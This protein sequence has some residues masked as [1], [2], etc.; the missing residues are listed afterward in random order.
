MSEITSAD[1]CQRLAFRDY[2][3]SHPSTANEYRVLK[4]RLAHEFPKDVAGYSKGKAGFIEN[5]LK[6]A[7]GPEDIA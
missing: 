4:A 5:V 3:R 7:L 6:A 1:W 2:L